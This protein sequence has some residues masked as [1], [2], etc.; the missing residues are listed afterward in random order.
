V[1][2]ALLPFFSEHFVAEF[3]SFF[4]EAL[5]FVNEW[6]GD[7][8]ID[9]LLLFGI[10]SFSLFVVYVALCFEKKYFL[11][12]CYLFCANAYFFCPFFAPF[13]LSK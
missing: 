9:D 11:G 5:Y 4:Y 7:E 6:W 13:F 8:G 10:P 12:R 2:G 3:F 1:L